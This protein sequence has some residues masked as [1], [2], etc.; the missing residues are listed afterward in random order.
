MR[1]NKVK[2][3]LRAGGVALGTMVLEFATTGITRLTADAGA[4]F[5][6]F[7]LEHTGWSLE[8]ARTVLA[9]ARPADFVPMVRVPAT[10]YH[11]VARVLDLGALGVMVPMVES[12]EQARQIVQF[13]KYPPQGRR[14]TAF[15]IAHDDYRDGD[16]AAKIRSA[17]QETLLIAQ[18]E[19]APGL[20]QVEGIAAVEGLDVLWIGHFDLTTSLGIPG[21]FEHPRYREAVRRVLAACQ[22]H[23]KAPGFMAASSEEGRALLGQGFRCLAYWG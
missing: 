4:D 13:A 7:D 20:E 3:T 14:G 22:R 21:E 23:G 11:F 5:L 9:A 15:G 18:I 2:R 10:Q 17:N 12:V 6:I 1:E 8:T 19:T 16:V